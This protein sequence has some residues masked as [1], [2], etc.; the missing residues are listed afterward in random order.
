MP[1]GRR[2]QSADLDE[3]A[4]FLWYFG[5]H[6]ISCEPRRR[7]FACQ[8]RMRVRLFQPVLLRWES[9]RSGSRASPR[10][11]VAPLLAETGTRWIG[12][13]MLD[14]AISSVL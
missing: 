9:I 13:A 8:S 14:D 5:I 1:F 4:G 3:E 7:A 12:G 6:G 11:P 10:A 2:S